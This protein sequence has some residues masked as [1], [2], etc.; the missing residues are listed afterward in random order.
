MNAGVLPADVKLSRNGD[1]LVMQISGTSDQLTVYYWFWQDRPDNMVEQIRFADGTVW[2]VPTIKQ[3]VLTGSPGSDTLVGY[4]TDDSLQGLAGRDTLWGRAGNDRL[5]GG[6]GADTMYGEGG[7][8][9]YVVDDLG[10]VVVEAVNAGVDT[11]ETAL[12]CSLPTNVENLTLTGQ[13]PINATGN[14]LGNTLTGNPAANILDGG[15]GT[16][17]LRG[18]PGN[19]TYRLNPGWGHDTIME[20]DSTPANV[21][22]VLFGAPVRPLDLVLRRTG[23]DLVLAQHATSDDVTIQSWYGGSAY[24]VEII[25]AGDGSRLLST[26][27]D[28]LIQ[29]M[30]SYTVSTGLTWDQAIDNRPQEV[31]NVLAGYWQPHS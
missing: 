7:D 9:S 10:D 13:S 11:V 31:Q 16:D 29:A 2:D 15:S 21:D 24:Q 28:G 19:D 4:A 23:D 14:A 3:M 27:L 30:A 1:H 25:Q 5:D 26:Q 22:T 18:G 20:N 6:A 8:D 12:T 17:T